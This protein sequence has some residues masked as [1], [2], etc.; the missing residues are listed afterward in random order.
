MMA[1]TPAVFPV[2]ASFILG[3]MSDVTC[4]GNFS[5]AKDHDSPR[6]LAHH[7]NE[8]FWAFC[9]DSGLIFSVARG[10]VRATYELT[11]I[12]VYEIRELW[13][14]VYQVQSSRICGKSNLLSE[15]YHRSSVN[16]RVVSRTQLALSLPSPKPNMLSAFFSFCMHWLTKGR[17]FHGSEQI[18]DNRH[19]Y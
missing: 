11:L 1:G 8:E 12:L 4:R 9:H 17:F 6:R 13:S 7:I 2:R 19:E 14:F 18:G 15:L 16:S 3:I 5:L 10:L